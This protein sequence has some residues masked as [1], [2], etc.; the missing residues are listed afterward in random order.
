MAPSMKN[1]E[2]WQKVRLISIAE[3]SW[4]TPHEKRRQ[5]QEEIQV[6]EYCSR[7]S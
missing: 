3:V 2:K 5:C 1:S 6:K 7:T 4:N